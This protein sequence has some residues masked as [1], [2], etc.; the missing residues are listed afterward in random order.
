M[1]TS[2]PDTKPA[3]LSSRIRGIALGSVLLIA[4]GAILVASRAAPFYLL[5]LLFVA[6]GMIDWPR[7]WREQARLA[8]HPLG[9]ILALIA[10]AALSAVWAR[11]A[12]AALG[13]SASALAIVVATYVGI[14]A[15]EQRTRLERLHVAEG[16]WIGLLA[17]ILY[18]VFETMTGQAIVRFFVNWL[19]I[20]PGAMNPASM[21]T[22][23]RGVLVSV[24]PV[25]MG[26]NIAPLTLLLWPALAAVAI[27][28]RGALRAGVIS[29]MLAG[30][31]YTVL[32]STHE[33]SK[34]ALVLGS[35]AWL[36]VAVRPRLGEKLIR[37][38]WLAACLLPIPIALALHGLDLHKQD[39]LP[40]SFKQRIE[41]WNTAAQEALE[42]PLLGSGAMTTYVES[43][44][45]AGG[46]S[47]RSPH[48][49]NVYL[50]VW[51]ELGLVG[52]LLLTLA[53][54]RIMDLAA[55][56]PDDRKAFAYAQVASGAAVAASSYGLWQ[57]W[58]M[59]AYGLAAIAFTVGL[60][61][62]PGSTFE[63]ESI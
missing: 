35:I 43:Q 37:T 60:R 7:A 29:L 27:C 34:L 50:Q 4:T 16:L 58:F 49:H 22:F 56:L 45:P 24:H 53:G 30:S 17:G 33:T 19:E 26:R 14:V 5:V 12:P 39:A 44:A 63:R 18:T 62:C 57:Y 11:N 2:L 1:F 21:Y 32:A 8:A 48:Q 6:A 13:K 38:A 46:Q 61:S 59:A 42:R 31:A 55:A 54:W 15:V 40:F 52:A 51:G 20:G 25:A 3:P 10:F 23:E 28:S 47:S 41:I 9:A 36:L